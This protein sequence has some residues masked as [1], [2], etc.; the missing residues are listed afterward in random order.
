MFPDRYFCKLSIA[1][2]H[3]IFALASTWEMTNATK[4]APITIHYYPI[5][6]NPFQSQKSSCSISAFTSKTSARSSSCGIPDVR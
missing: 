4:V 6:R 1:T 3:A 5:F 2:K